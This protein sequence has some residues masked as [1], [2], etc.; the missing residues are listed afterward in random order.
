[1]LFPL[2]VFFF[3]TFVLC[4]S[5]STCSCNFSIRRPPNNLNTHSPPLASP[6][7]FRT[8][9]IFVISTPRGI[10]PDSVFQ[11]VVHLSFPHMLSIQLYQSIVSLSCW[12]TGHPLFGTLERIFWKSFAVFLNSC[13]LWHFPLHS[14]LH[15]FSTISFQC[16]PSISDSLF[17]RRTPFSCQTFILGRP[18]HLVGNSLPGPP[19]PLHLLLLWLL[20]HS[21]Q[22]LPELRSSSPSVNN[23]SDP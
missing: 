23:F 18:S 21:P 17:C 14:F 4:F 10:P 1:V 13:P 20:P 7:I 5:V 12:T 11:Q 6:S 15:D 8:S 2:Q 3:Q 19:T 22:G 9:V 16:P